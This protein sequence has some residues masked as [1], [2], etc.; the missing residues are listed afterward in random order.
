MGIH[1]RLRMTCAFTLCTLHFAFCTFSLALEPSLSVTDSYNRHNLSASGPGTPGITKVQPSGEKRVCIFCHTPHHASSVTPL[2]SRD[3]SDEIYTPYKSTTL[4]ATPKPGQ[5]T[6]ASRLCLSC[7]DGTIALS[8]LTGG[9]DIGG[10]PKLSAD[11]LS[12]LTTDLSDDHPISF[13]YASAVTPYSGLRQESALPREIRLEKGNL[14]CTACHD[15]HKDLFPPTDDPTKSG[16][17]LVLDN[18]S[19]SALCVACHQMPG[20][21]LSAHYTAK[22]ACEK[23]H[24]SHAAPQPQRLLKGATLQDT[25]L[26]NCHNGSS[27]LTEKGIDIRS[28]FSLAKAHQPGAVLVSGKHDAGEN[29]LDFTAESVHV[30]CVDC[31]NPCLVRHEPKPQNLSSP[32]SINGRL[33]EVTI[34]KAP[35]GS[36][37]MATKE[38][39][40]CFKCHALQHFTPAAIPRQIQTGDEAARF[41]IDNP[42]SHPVTVARTGTPVPSL[43]SEIAGFTPTRSL[44]TQ[45]MI[46][47]TDCHN[48]DNS[49]KVKVGSTGATG[50]HGSANRHILLDTYEQDTYPLAYDV[51]N[52]A[53]C[54]RCHDQDVLLTPLR[55]NFPPHQSH[56]VTH[57]VPCS[58]CHD[59]HGVPRTLGATAARN[60]HL[61]NFETLFGITGSYASGPGHTGSCTVTPCHTTGS[62]DPK[63]HSY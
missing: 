39:E 24:V 16:N 50:P 62:P 30:E 11:R 51:N 41:D 32:P 40:I 53:L 13:A 37:T 12:N 29:P 22:Q 63:T 36:R 46:Y 42:S 5:P 31:H 57:Q 4:Q 55:T 47:C 45:R 26:V 14:E 2:W 17:F 56:V 25:C 38:F 9:H 27:P 43:R 61:I 6:G 33:A 1:R 21:N 7:H 19:Y 48:S 54:F 3:L 60:A 44:L 35:D 34:V 59:P 8:M 15:P 49:A 58:I 23:C 20:L 52:Y 28:T 10:L 18:N